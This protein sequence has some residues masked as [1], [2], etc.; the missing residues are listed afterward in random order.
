MVVA[1]Q[2]MSFKERVPEGQAYVFYIDIRSAGKGYDEYVQR[3]M[4][5]HG[6]LAMGKDLKHAYYLADLTE[7]TAKIAYMAATIPDRG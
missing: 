1:K 7:D 5:E 2:A 3:G 6:I 4:E